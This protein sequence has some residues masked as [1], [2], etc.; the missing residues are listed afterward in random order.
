MYLHAL[1]ILS[2]ALVINGCATQK[3]ISRDDYVKENM[4]FFI[5]KFTW[6]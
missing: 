5:S 2:F 1:F 6:S 4:A 3:P